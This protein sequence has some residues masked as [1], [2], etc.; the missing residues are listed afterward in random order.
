MGLTPATTL[1]FSGPDGRTP[2]AHA[3]AP[4]SDEKSTN[5]GIRPVEVIVLLI[6]VVGLAL[7]GVLA[8]RYGRDSRDWLD[9]PFPGFIERAD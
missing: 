8:N 7:I 2:D 4:E 5:E 9:K 3:G 6:T 1:W